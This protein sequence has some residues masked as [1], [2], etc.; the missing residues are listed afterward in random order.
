MKLVSPVLGS[1]QTQQPQG[2]SRRNFLKTT[3]AGVVG[4][5]SGVLPGLHQAEADDRIHIDPNKKTIDFRPKDEKYETR[6]QEI[7]NN[8]TKAGALKDEKDFTRTVSVNRE[9]GEPITVPDSDAYSEYVEGL[10]AR[11]RVFDDVELF[12]SVLTM[13]HDFKG[14]F[15]KTQRIISDNTGD[16][17]IN[18]Y[19]YRQSANALGCLNTAVKEKR[20]VNELRALVPIIAH[21]EMNINTPVY[22]P[23]KGEIALN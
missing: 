8:A 10:K 15:N 4:L 20:D 11:A 7:I 1:E 18:H 16:R 22:A 14:K 13:V 23:P 6:L 5:A 12:G 9:T 2:V 21:R 19:D 3:G 17:F